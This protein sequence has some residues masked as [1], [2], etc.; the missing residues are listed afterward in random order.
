MLLTPDKSLKQVDS[1]TVGTSYITVSKWKD[2]GKKCV[3]VVS[4]MHSV[5][6][7]STAERMS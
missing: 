6:E 7:K 4:T 2:R 3:S 1:D 5:T